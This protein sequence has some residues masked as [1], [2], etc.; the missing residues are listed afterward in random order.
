M[1]GDIAKNA[2][3]KLSK[4][5]FSFNIEFCTPFKGTLRR[6]AVPPLEK[7]H[8]KGKTVSTF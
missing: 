3:K 7:E 4:L 8:K 5:F 1:S 2:K 6:F